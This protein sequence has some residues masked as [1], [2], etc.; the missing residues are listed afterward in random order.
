MSTP[1][2]HRGAA[3]SHRP[4]ASPVRAAA[5]ALAL[6]LLV[7]SACRATGSGDATAPGDEEA[8]SPAISSSLDGPRLGRPGTNT[9]SMAFP[10]GVRATSGILLEKEMPSEVIRG[11]EF[12]YHIL[13]E[14]LTDRT[15]EAVEVVDAL[16]EGVEITATEPEAK[17]VGRDAIWR[18]GALP[19][20]SR[21]ILSVRGVPGDVAAFATH[22]TVTYESRLTAGAKVIAPA[23][24][25][26]MEV[27]GEALA[28][29]PL[30]VT[31]RVANVGSGDAREVRVVEELPEG[32]R[33][34]AGRQRVV[35]EFGT[36]AGG[37]SKERTVDVVADA[38]GA[39][40]QA[41]TA[42]GAGGLAAESTPVTTV[43]RRPRLT[44]AVEAPERIE[45]LRPISGRVVVSNTG[46]APSEVVTLLAEFPA[47][48]EVRSATGDAAVAEDPDAG[49]SIAWE[50][51]PL[52]VG[53]SRAFEYAVASLTGR[54]FIA[55]VSA[56]GRCAG[57]TTATARTDV[58][59]RPAVVVE[60]SGG[61]A[62]P[63][64][65]ITAELVLENVGSSADTGLTVSCVVPDGVTIAAATGGE[66]A[67]IEGA[68]AT[69]QPIPELAPGARVVLRLELTAAGAARGD[70]RVEL[71]TDDR[72]SALRDSA[73]LVFGE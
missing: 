28:C 24:E 25:L 21:K 4:A 62:G 65:T 46:D 48:T 10:T 44:L 70:L 20:H 31:F 37:Q 8:A 39:Y 5:A 15:L 49:A 35:L 73:T 60:A 30:P 22:A 42:E 72:E 9:Y 2:L 1:T 55:K 50:V 11:V 32:L 40:T 63:G 23:L 45:V 13:V 61:A 67:A 52:A 71:T 26:E 64:E 29:D 12:E 38:A 16:P 34:S 57:E 6:V 17:L 3:S 7:A 53:E 59:G 27:P 56:S 69:F 36:L 66:G 54:A 43:L 58:A 18:L 51:Q 68:R 47:R 41:A 14:N 19:E 33:T